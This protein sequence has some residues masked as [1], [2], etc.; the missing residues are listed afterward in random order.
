MIICDLDDFCDDD[1]SMEDLKRLRSIRE[2]IP[3]FKVTLFT[4][5]GRCSPEFISWMRTAHPWCDLVQHGWNHDSN[6]ECKA[7]SKQDCKDF[8]AAGRDLG[9]TTR[10]FKAPGWQIS[11]GCYEALLEEGYWVADQLYNDPR[12]PSMA[13]YVLWTKMRFTFTGRGLPDIKV[14]QIHGHIG[15]LGGHNGNALEFI[16]PQILE[17]GKTD[18][19]F[20]FINEV[21]V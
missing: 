3:T 9:I 2:Q 7:W 6:Y 17:A 5:P 8:L 1:R 11:D 14:L 20:R 16:M 4:I 12:R 21:M 15:H 13:A 18:P 10:G 19:D